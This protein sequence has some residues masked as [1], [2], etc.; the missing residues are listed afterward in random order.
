V[1]TSRQIVQLRRLDLTVEIAAD[2]TIWTE[3][4]YKFTKATARDA[5]EGAGLI[6][7]HWHSDTQRRFALV[8]A[9]PA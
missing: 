4:S 3:N 5:L 2:E 6:M 9:A 8:V 7:T 1:P